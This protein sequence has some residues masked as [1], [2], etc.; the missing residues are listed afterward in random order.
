MEDI[1]MRIQPWAIAFSFISFLATPVTAQFQAPDDTIKALYASYGIGD[2]VQTSKSGFNDK[3]AAQVLD[4]TLLDLYKRAADSGGMD[5]DF[6]IQGQ[7]FSLAKPIEINQVSITGGK[8][9]VSATL[10]Q[11]DFANG[12]STTNHFV[13]VLVKT[14]KG[15]LLDNAFYD[16][17]SARDEWNA[18]LKQGKMK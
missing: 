14:T 2:P 1:D 8:A 9:Q 11:N 6:F 7:D 13:F 16:G 15:W 5:V 12:R 17:R 10:L 3:L 4:Q 18:E